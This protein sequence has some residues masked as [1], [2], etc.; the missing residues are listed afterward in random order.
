[1]L[2]H[3]QLQHAQVEP[4]KSTSSVPSPCVKIC[5]IIDNQCIGCDRTTDEIREWF[6]CDD[7]RKKEILERIS[8]G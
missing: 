7:E 3:S 2:I 1:M 6:Y 5:T 4:V 8:N